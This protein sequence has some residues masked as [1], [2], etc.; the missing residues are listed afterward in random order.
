MDNTAVSKL[1]LSTILLSLVLTKV[2][3]LPVSSA[4]YCYTEKWCGPELWYDTFEGCAQTFAL[5]QSPVDL[6]P[7]YM[8]RNMS[9]AP[10]KL[11]GY[12]KLQSGS[13]SVINIRDTV[14]VKVGPGMR[15]KGGSL[16]D[17]YETLYI[18]FHWGSAKSNGSEHTY[19]Q[20][21]YPME[22]QIFHAVSPF[23]DVRTVIMEVPQAVAVLC[24]FI[25]IGP[26]D[27][28]VFEAISGAIPSIPLP[29]D[30]KSIPPFVLRNLLPDDTSK[31]YRYPGSLH[32]PPCFYGV[33]YAV[34]EDPIY[35]SQKQYNHFFTGVYYHEPESPKKMLLHDNYRHIHPLF[36][37]SISTSPNA[38][39]PKRSSGSALAASLLAVLV[40]SLVSVLL[41]R[42]A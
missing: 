19:N 42:V 21:R 23:T 14:A 17:M 38:T 15:I 26:E 27:N 6:N 37:R 20:R 9:M 31:F 5:Q 39:I 35:I 1:A 11:E 13:W 3:S 4:D 25:D 40:A 12:D 8:I 24:V 29:G 34:F 16:P 10:L 33:E 28:P 22:M 30:K 18:A 41:A 7:V 32:F 36:D 2:S